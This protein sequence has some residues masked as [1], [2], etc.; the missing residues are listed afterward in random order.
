MAH[1][2]LSAAARGEI[3][4]NPEF[5][6][7]QTDTSSIVPVVR[8]IM[9]TKGSLHLIQYYCTGPSLPGTPKG[10]VPVSKFIL[11]KFNPK[12]NLPARRKYPPGG[13]SIL[14]EGRI[15]TCVPSPLT[16]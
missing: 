12:E 2:V 7:N 14:P 9:V 13:G 6:F 11:D 4:N 5:C 3:C 1:F 16:W 8:R 15:V 10:A